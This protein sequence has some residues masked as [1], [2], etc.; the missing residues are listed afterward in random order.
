MGAADHMRWFLDAIREPGE[1]VELRALRVRQKYGKPKT[2]AGYFRFPDHFDALCESALA[3]TPD[4]GGV[5]VTMNPVNPALLGRYY[6]RT[7]FDPEHTTSDADIL[8]R[9]WLLVDVDPTRPAGI[10]ASDA[11]KVAAWE[12]TERVREYLTGVWEAAPLVVDSGNGFHLY[13]PV[14]LPRDDGGQVERILKQLAKRFDIP[15]ATVDSSTFNPSRITKLPGTYARKGDSIPD[16]PHRPVKVV[17]V[18][19]A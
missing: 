3:L 8:R 7:E 9:A 5:Y 17:E 14:D 18:P 16:R 10:S 13:Y 4:A 12:L 2:A 19:G 6:R 1:V 11:E 15:H